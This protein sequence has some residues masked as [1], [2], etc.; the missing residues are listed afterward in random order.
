ME[1]ENAETSRPVFAPP[2]DMVTG[3]QI[4]M[5]LQAA[6]VM[7]ACAKMPTDEPPVGGPSDGGMQMAAEVSF[8]KVCDR[9]DRLVSDDERWSMQAQDTL[10]KDMSVMLKAQAGAA[11]VHRK[12]ASIA[13]LPHRRLNPLLYKISDDAWVAYLGDLCNPADCV[14]GVGTFPQEALQQFDSVYLGSADGR[15]HQALFDTILTNLNK[16]RKDLIPNEN[17][18]DT[19][20]GHESDNPE[21][22]REDNAGSCPDNGADI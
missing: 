6:R 15:K 1:F 17:T 5:L 16:T 18:M 21:T 12:V 19:G 10:E 4:G 14:L 20:T 11:D 13:A 3:N 9:L 8:V 2:R 7:A 22:E